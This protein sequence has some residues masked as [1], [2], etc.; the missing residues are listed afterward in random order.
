MSS[1]LNSATDDAARSKMLDAE[2]ELADLTEKYGEIAADAG[3]AAASLLPPPA[4]TAADVISL[5]KSLITGDW[6]GA[7]LDVVGFV[8][9]AGDAIK[10]AG[11][12]TKLAKRM[13][14]IEDAIKV[15]K[16]ALARKRAAFIA[17]RK[18]AA[19]KYWSDIKKKGKAAYDEAIKKA[20]VKDCPDDFAKL[21]GEHYQ[22]NPKTGKNGSWTGERGD[23]DWIPTKGSDLDKALDKFNKSQKPPTT[24]DRV[25]Y[26]GGFPKYDNFVYKT[27]DGR[28]ARVEIPQVGGRKDFATADDAMR[29]MLG[30]PD[31][32]RPKGYTWHHKQ[33]GVT[34]ELVPTDIHGFPETGHAGGSSVLEN[35]DF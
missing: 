7:L 31:W 33:D 14:Q 4:G 13:A 16:A 2:K 26:E 23:G 24:F 19:L 29:E 1:T 10:A 18:D 35:P 3:L 25:P 21:K 15:A 17:A 30:D 28:A 12:G 6:G 32:V 20:S 8:P 9:L 11:K 34:M 5:G 22:Y 27:P